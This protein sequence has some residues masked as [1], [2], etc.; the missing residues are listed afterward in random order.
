VAVERLRQQLETQATAGDI[1]AAASTAKAL[2]RASPASH[3][4][5]SEM[6]RVLVL[7]Y[8]HLAKTQFAAGQVGIALQTLQE[9]H[10][11]F[12][13]STELKDIEA[14]YVAAADVYD[15]LRTAVILN[16]SDTRSALEELKARDGDEYDVTAQMLAQTLADRIAD[17]RAANRSTVA[18]RLLESG[19][20]VFP[21]YTG[22]LAHGTAGVL[23]NDPIAISD[24]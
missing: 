19:K 2:T 24:E 7:S 4:V 17:Q 10:R 1:T 18:D 11:K 22:I 20:Q 23:Q 3:Y 14:R 21:G 5:V 6:P 9:G 16:V 8:V 13:R 12:G 15:R